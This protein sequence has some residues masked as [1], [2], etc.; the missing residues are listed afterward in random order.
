MAWTLIP[1]PTNPTWSAVPKPTESSVMN[2]VGDAEPWGMLLAITSVHSDPSPSI[3]SGW[4]DIAKPAS[5]LWTL[6]TKPTS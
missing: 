3:I 2:A 1:K 5:S 4:T 6:V